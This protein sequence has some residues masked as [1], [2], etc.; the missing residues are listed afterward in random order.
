MEEICANRRPFN[1][2]TDQHGNSGRS[3]ATAQGIGPAIWQL[4]VSTT[5]VN[6]KKLGP[7]GVL[8]L[9]LLLS[10]GL[11]LY[12]LGE[13]NIWWDE[14]HAIWTARQG[15]REA[16]AITARDVHPPLYLWMLGW[17]IQV[18]GES[19]MAVRYLS[20]IGGVLTVALTY[21]VARRLVGR[22]AA[23]LATLLIAAARFHIWWSQETRMYV[24][25]TFFALL[26][27]YFFIRLRHGSPGHWWGYVFASLA[28]LYTLYLAA[29]VLVLENIFVLVTVWKQPRWRRTL[30]SWGLAQLST[31]ALYT[32]WLYAA[33]SQSRT[34]SGRTS[35]PLALVW[36]LYGTVLTTGI[37]TNLD[38]YL[39][40]VLIIS[41]LALAGAFLLFFDRHQP[42]RYGFAG[43]EV[44]LLLLL[45]L[46]LPPL[47][48]WGL[49]LPRG[50]YYSPKP[51]A[52][53]LLLLSPL[54]YTLLA[55]SMAYYW[56]RGRWGRTVTATA[57]LAVLGAFVA[58]LPGYYADRYL[59]DDYHTAMCILAAYSHPDDA[60]LLVSGDRYPLFMYRYNR[61]FP[62]GGPP[63]YFMPRTHVRFTVENVEQELRPLAE[64]HRRMWLASFERNIQDPD[65]LAEKWLDA[66]LH[67]A[68]TVPQ[69]YNF[70]RLYTSDGARPT[71]NSDLRPQHPL[72]DSLGKGELVGYDLPTTEFRPG[73]VVRPG[74]YLRAGRPLTLTVEWVD[75][76]G[77]V[78]EQQQMAMEGGAARVMPSFAVFEYTPAGH[79]RVVVYDDTA[80]RRVVLDAGRVT[81][82]RRLPRPHIA[83]SREL[84]LGDGNIH[85]LGYHLRPGSRVQQGKRMQVELYWKTQR[86]IS[87]DYTVFVHLLG[88]FNPATGGPVWAQ[89]D[90]PPLD[91]GHPT[92]RWLPGEVIGDRH[93]FTIPENAPPGEYQIEAGMYDPRTGERLAVPGSDQG[94][95]LLATIRVTGR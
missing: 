63:V 21:V 44:G 74:L 87:V 64:Q 25:A 86:R 30:F 94:R 78:I 80:S 42:Q 54:F 32:P 73:D 33:L 68:L 55:G 15:P 95:I 7:T 51:E 14:G 48:V 17:W 75:G 37:S 29:L 46:V 40:L 4:S 82:T 35:F 91:G 65:G 34:D 6:L 36:Q 50:M 10:F 89:D 11:R 43:W 49:S 13:Q 93:T 9:I 47:V 8:L 52:R 16:A 59:R 27:L 5:G 62:E 23:L 77:R 12:R 90:S 24:W 57:T 85:F 31:F 26:S 19:E 71:L 81:R 38:R 67:P 70:L 66:H 72:A 28:A 92:T 41:T 45:P 76:K 69:G 20:L 22:R 61:S 60:V 3:K 84:A 56:Q 79:Y 53:Y 18:A 39:W 83:V 88:P 1:R 58:V 2:F